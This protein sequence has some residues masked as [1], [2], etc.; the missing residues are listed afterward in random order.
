MHVVH[1]KT[2]YLTQERAMYEKDGTIVLAYLFQVTDS[3]SKYGHVFSMTPPNVQENTSVE[4]P[5]IP[6]DHFLTPFGSNYFLYFGSVKTDKNSYLLQW[7]VHS[8]IACVSRCEVNNLLCIMA[9]IN[10]PTAF[11]RMKPENDDVF[12]V[13]DNDISHEFKHSPST[14]TGIIQS[15]VHCKKS[16]SIKSIQFKQTVCCCGKG[17]ICQLHPA[18][19]FANS[20]TN[21]HSISFGLGYEPQMHDCASHKKKASK[22]TETCDECTFICKPEKKKKRKSKKKSKKTDTESDMCETSSDEFCESICSICSSICS[23]SGKSSQSID[24][25]KTK[26]KPSKSK[27]PKPAKKE[28]GKKPEKS[29]SSEDGG[30]S[31]AKSKKKEKPEKGK[32]D[33]GKAKEDTEEASETENEEPEAEAKGKGKGKGKGK[34][35]KGKE[36]GETNETDDD[37]APKAKEKSKKAPK[38]KGKGKSEDSDVDNTDNDSKPVEK[39][40]KQE[41]DEDLT[42]DKSNSKANV[43]KKGKKEKKET[44]EKKEKKG[45]GEKS[46]SE[47]DDES[48]A[49]EERKPERESVSEQPK[50]QSPDGASFLL[51][52]KKV[53]ASRDEPKACPDWNSTNK[54]KSDTSDLEKYSCKSFVASTTSFV[55][56]VREELRKRE[57]ALRQALCNKLYGKND[58]GI[59]TLYEKKCKS[60]TAEDSPTERSSKSKIASECDNI[61]LNFILTPSTMRNNSTDEAD[62]KDEKNEDVVEE[63]SS[64]TFWSIPTQTSAQTPVENGSPQE[65]QPSSISTEKGSKEFCLLMDHLFRAEEKKGNDKMW[66]YQEYHVAIERDQSVLQEYNGLLEP[67]QQLTPGNYQKLHLVP[68]YKETKP[69]NV[70]LTDCSIELENPKDIRIRAKFLVK[71]N[72]SVGDVFDQKPPGTLL[73]YLDAQTQYVV[74]GSL[75][76]KSSEKLM[77]TIDDGTKHTLDNGQ[78][79][80]TGQTELSNKLSDSF[81]RDTRIS[82]KESSPVDDGSGQNH[83]TRKSL[84]NGGSD[85]RL[86]DSNS[87]PHPLES[88]ESNSKEKQNDNY[89]EEK[90]NYTIEKSHSSREEKPTSLVPQ[91]SRGI[92]EK[93]NYSYKVK[94]IVSSTSTKTAYFVCDRVEHDGKTGKRIFVGNFRTKEEINCLSKS[95]SPK[96]TTS[97]A[98][99][100]GN[101]HKR[102]ERNAENSNS[103]KDIVS[104]ESSLSRMAEWC[105]KQLDLVSN[106]MSLSGNSKEEENKCPVGKVISRTR[107]CTR[108]SECLTESSKGHLQQSVFLNLNSPT[109]Q[110]S[111]PPKETGED[112]VKKTVMKTES[113]ATSLNSEDLVACEKGKEEKKQEEGKKSTKR[114]KSKEALIVI[115]VDVESL[116]KVELILVEHLDKTNVNDSNDYI[117]CLN[118]YKRLVLP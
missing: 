108:S 91:K 42:S 7:F 12:F 43:K 56:N 102:L 55:H 60:P 72:V 9:T 40:K 46:S 111:N 78:G 48:A 61:Q 109:E 90:T 95:N 96:Q 6:L 52:C 18:P 23:K 10:P 38:A 57:R 35:A 79:F 104:N 30:K 87:A 116:S 65:A 51:E 81:Q 84:S 54:I 105:S 49:K 28:K 70:S 3:P 34:P 86:I 36:K 58:D 67:Q 33:K 24:K 113:K 45:K 89:T 93:E 63:K 50:S 62:P 103:A 71:E 20:S 85:S 2:S 77:T 83:L 14:A 74:E 80:G 13:Q 29:K 16:G 25:K 110:E 97:T 11:R 53:E 82:T 69:L 107:K 31:D 32:K 106:N 21:T 59:Q 44:K 118:S 22:W 101:K 88:S 68:K 115:P 100:N 94:K 73:R 1:Y 5:Q 114:D 75:P 98:S 66:N 41:S 26:S 117:P 37:S 92:T 15:T 64:N 27:I 39:S 76:C 99:L 112:T 47:E 17:Q 4:L 19:Q 8:K